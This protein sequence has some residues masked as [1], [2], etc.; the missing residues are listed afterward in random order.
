[1]AEV[2]QSRRPFAER[3]LEGRHGCQR[4]TDP[5]NLQQFAGGT[6]GGNDTLTEAVGEQRGFQSVARR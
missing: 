3:E 5:K 6:V 2:R 1:M 4:R